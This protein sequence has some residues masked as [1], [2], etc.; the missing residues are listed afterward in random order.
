LDGQSKVE[1]VYHRGKL[2]IQNIP[3]QQ[4]SKVI[5]VIAN[6][7]PV[8]GCI[9]NPNSKNII[10]KSFKI[11]QV[12]PMPWIKGTYSWK[13]KYTVAHMTA[14]EVPMAAPKKL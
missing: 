13:A 7:E 1:E 14:A 12:V 11:E 3:G 2:L 6:T 5:D 8:G 10:N 9:S 4:L